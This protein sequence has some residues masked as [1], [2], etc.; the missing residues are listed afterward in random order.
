MVVLAGSMAVGF[1]AGLV[2]SVAALGNPG[3]IAS[4]SPE[5]DLFCADDVFGDAVIG[6]AL[7][8]NVSEPHL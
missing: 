4:L 6:A 3:Q 5:R 7:H 2:S 1:L 8:D